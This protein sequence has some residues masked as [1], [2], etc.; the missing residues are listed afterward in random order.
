MS[1]EDARFLDELRAERAI[2]RVLL[3][4]GRGVDEA[5]WERVRA[6]FHQDARI[7]YG[8]RKSGIR[9]EIVAW[10]AEVDP[11]LLRL[12]HYFGPP[13]IEF[14]PEPGVARCQTWCIDVMQ[15]HP[16]PQGRHAQRVMGLFYTDR[17]ECRDGQWRIA[18]RRNATEWIFDVKGNPMA[19]L[20]PAEASAGNSDAS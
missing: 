18:E 20:R 17:F 3:E 14:G 2:R 12:S 13:I 6:C 11:L 19:D 9:D 10:L 7:T 8:E 5:D 4:Y 15:Y 16:S 1:E